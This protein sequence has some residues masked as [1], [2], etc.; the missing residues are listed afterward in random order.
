MVIRNLFS[1][2]RMHP[3]PETGL[4]SAAST[5]ASRAW[6]PPLGWRVASWIL[7]GFLCCV[8]GPA[9]IAATHGLPAGGGGTPEQIFDAAARLYEQ[10]RVAEA[11]AIYQSLV[12]NG[13]ATPALLFNQGNAWLAAGQ[14]GRAIVSYRAARRLA[15]RDP[16]IL[17]NLARARARVGH[18]ATTVEGPAARV[19]RMLTGN[20]WGAAALV[21]VWLWFGLLAARE[22]FPRW[23]PQTTFL[24]RSFAVL[25]LVAGV[26]TVAAG[27]RGARTVIVVIAPD[28]AV[29]FGPLE[30]SQPAFTLPDGAELVVTDRK[31]EWLEVRDAAGRRGWI[32][33]RHV[34]R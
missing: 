34:A 27:V 33:E 1:R 28:T 10:G 16:E 30:E 4:G 8:V 32:L 9:T 11:A 23:K 13:V 17:A 19:L 20:E 5:G 2:G 31:G 25:A 12:T 26:G 7:A 15:P 22:C 29:R 6:L 3:R 21:G 18:G 24:A 14:V